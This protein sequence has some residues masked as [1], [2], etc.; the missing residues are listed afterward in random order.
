[1]FPRAFADDER[2]IEAAVDSLPAGHG[3]PWLLCVIPFFDGN[4]HRKGFFEVINRNGVTAVAR[5]AMF[6]IPAVKRRV[7][8]GVWA[9]EVLHAIVGWPDLYKANG[10]Q[11]GDF[12]NMTFNA[13]THSC[14][15]LKLSAGWL[16]RHRSESLRPPGQV[17]P[18]FDQPLTGAAG[19]RVGCAHQVHPHGERVP[20]RGAS[21]K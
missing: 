11:L 13:G 5:V 1:M 6:D 19:P 2:V 15:H 9:M 14:A 8:T 18:A 16:G 10:P 20:R 4:V 12:D 17:R 21:A 3:F 7:I